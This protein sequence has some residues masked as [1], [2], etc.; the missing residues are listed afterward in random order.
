MS[1]GLAGHFPAAC[2]ACLT[3]SRSPKRRAATLASCRHVS[4]TLGHRRIEFEQA[5][6]TSLSDA[7]HA[8][9]EPRSTKPRKLPALRSPCL[10]RMRAW[11][12]QRGTSIKRPDWRLTRPSVT[13]KR[14]RR[15]WL[16]P[17]PSRRHVSH[18]V[19]WA[20]LRRPR[21]SGCCRWWKVL[22]RWALAQGSYPRLAVRAR[23]PQL[24]GYA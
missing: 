3:N 5:L 11:G 10:Q 8:R 9:K 4:T 17:A 23:R 7:G 16:R 22:T 6:T 13:N 19:S 14:A 12:R 1:P 21:W 18:V 24:P 20:P 2:R 15:R